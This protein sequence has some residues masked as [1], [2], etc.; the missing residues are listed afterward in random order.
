VLLGWA[1]FAARRPGALGAAA[2]PPPVG[3]GL[4]ARGRALLLRWGASLD[5][6]RE[7]R[8]LALALGI[9]V[10]MK[11]AEAAGWWAVERALG[12][13]PRPGSPVLAL[14]ATN[15]AS[16]IRRR[17]ATWACTRARRTRPTTPCSACPR[18]TAVAL[19]LLGPRVLPGAAG[20]DGVGAA[21]V[22]AAAGAAGGPQ[23]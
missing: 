1:A 17:R 10:L 2:A 8:R 7:P 5:A 23:R 21:D 6:V 14:A 12:V 20:R 3:R 15:L 18:E 22:A 16:A 9:A 4:A 11:A 19:A 13:A